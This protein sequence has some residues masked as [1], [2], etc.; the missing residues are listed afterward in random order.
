M[1]KMGAVLAA[2]SGQREG[3]G[4]GGGIKMGLPEKA[5]HQKG[6]IPNGTIRPPSHK[7]KGQEQRGWGALEETEA[8]GH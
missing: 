6:L 8:K 7:S 5:G 4:V 3:A 1:G 2:G